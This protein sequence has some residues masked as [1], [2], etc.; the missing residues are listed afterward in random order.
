M[1][2]LCKMFVEFCNYYLKSVWKD[3][4]LVLEKDAEN[5]K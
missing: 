1:C 4:C 3:I 5:W 2:K